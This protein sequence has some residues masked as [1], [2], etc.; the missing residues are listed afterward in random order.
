MVGPAG[1]VHTTLVV[2]MLVGVVSAV[3]ELPAIVH[4]PI[5]TTVSRW[6]AGGGCIHLW[7]VYPVLIFP[8]TVTSVEPT[9]LRAIAVESE[10]TV[11]SSAI[12]DTN[13]YAEASPSPA[14]LEQN[15]YSI[16]PSVSMNKSVSNNSQILRDKQS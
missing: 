13:R 16:L 5:G 14:E 1:V 6:L 7:S 12:V 8:Y 10:D 15:T 11:V 2:E 9:S 3:H 4:T